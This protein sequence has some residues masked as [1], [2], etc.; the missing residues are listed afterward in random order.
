MTSRREGD[1]VE[2]LNGLTQPPKEVNVVDKI[3]IDLD[4]FICN[5]MK[6]TPTL[7]L[8]GEQIRAEIEETIKNGE[9]K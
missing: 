8:L 6:N 5:K 7:K 9:E 4:P 3:F 2:R 1:I